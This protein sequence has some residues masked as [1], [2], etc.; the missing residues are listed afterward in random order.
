MLLD[1]DEELKKSSLN[2]ELSFVT[3]HRHLAIRALLSHYPEPKDVV[4]TNCWPVACAKLCEDISTFCLLFPPTTCSSGCWRWSVVLP[5]PIG[6]L[7]GSRAHVGTRTGTKLSHHQWPTSPPP[8]SQRQQCPGHGETDC[9]GCCTTIT[10]ATGERRARTFVWTIPSAR[11][12]ERR[13]PSQGP[14]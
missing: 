2:Q 12:G 10:A 4:L 9:P 11:M 1:V 8:P 6:R 5:S 7:E 13:G 14:R 3:T